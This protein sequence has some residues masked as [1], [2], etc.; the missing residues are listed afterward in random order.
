MK[1]VYP[2]VP[3]LAGVLVL[4]LPAVAGA[5]I[6]IAES[7]DWVV[8]DSDRV[9]AGKVVQV[10]TVAGKDGKKYEVAT[11]AVATT[12]KGEHSARAAFLLRYYNGP[13]ARDW[14]ADGIPMVFCLVKKARVARERGLPAGF[15]WVL[16]DDGNN[17]C[18]VLLGKSKRRWTFTVPV[19]TREFAVLTDPDAIRQ[20][21]AQAA[22]AVKKGQVPRR[23]TLMVP[24]DTEVY[25]KLW[26]RSAVMLTVP[27]DDHLEALGRH[28]CASRSYG[29]RIEGA[30]ILGYFKNEKNIRLLKAL[31]RDPDSSIETQHRTVAGRREMVLVYRK[32]VYRVRQLAYE[33]LRAFGVEVERPVLEQVLERG[34]AR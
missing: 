16:R 32:R 17:H 1:R 24:A 9:F 29:E 23:H 28:W 31:L 4:A 15:A 10:E 5:E 12:F 33:A 7:I 22:R 6:A 14:L 25:R 34:P 18:A 8:A 19:L 3:V 26:S 2:S 27:V 21:V 13:I 11:V 30:R 20:R